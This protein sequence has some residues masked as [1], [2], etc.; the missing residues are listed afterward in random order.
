[1]SLI[2]SLTAAPL[3]RVHVCAHVCCRLCSCQASGSTAAQGEPAPAA[4]ATPRPGRSQR[5]PGHQPAMQARHQLLPSTAC[6]VVHLG[7]ELASQPQQ[8][9][10]RRQQRQQRPLLA[11]PQRSSLPVRQ[12]DARRVPAAAGAAVEAAARQRQQQQ[13]QQQQAPLLLP[14][15]SVMAVQGGPQQAQHASVTLA[16]A[17]SRRRTQM[18]WQQ[19]ELLPQP[20]QQQLP[21]RLTLKGWSRLGHGCTGRLC[22]WRESSVG[23]C[24]T[25]CHCQATRPTLSAVHSK[26]H[27]PGRQRAASRGGLGRARVAAASGQRLRRRAGRL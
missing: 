3:W 12:Q 10:Q 17:G 6:L 13:Q 14:G 23:T 8:Q 4:T 7:A 20:Q 2:Q 15:R 16:A 19:S 27:R 11:V 22:L 21:A 9:L 26:A 1:M 25:S 18:L 24:C 5:K